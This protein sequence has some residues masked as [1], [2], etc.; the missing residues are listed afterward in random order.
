MMI[1]VN[2]L[3]LDFNEDIE[4][5]KQAKVFE[6]IDETVGDFSYSFSLGKTSRN[7]TVL[8]IET[9]DIAN[10]TIYRNV[11]AEILDDDGVTIYR[12]ILRVE[13]INEVIECSFY[14]GN[15]NWISKITGNLSDLDFSEYDINLTEANIIAS[16]ASTEGIVF[17][18][19]DTGGLITRSQP[20]LKIEDFNG[21]MYVKTIFKKIFQGA[22]IKL[23]G[24]LINDFIY[25]NSIVV[26]NNKDQSDIDNRSSYVLKNTTTVLTSSGTSIKMTWNDDSTSPYFDGSEDNFNLSLSRYEADVKMVVQVVC[27]LEFED[28]ATPTANFVIVRVNGSPT[29]PPTSIGSVQNIVTLRKLV[30]LNAGDY[31][32][33]FAQY[34]SGIVPNLDVISGTLKIT[35]VF[36]Y[37]VNGSSAVPNWTRQD[38]VAQYLNLFNVVTDYDPVSKELTCNFFDRI[39]AR[40]SIDISNYIQPDPP[41]D[42]ED[43]ISNYGRQ[44]LFSYDDGDDEELRSYNVTKFIKYGSGIIEVENDFI[45]ET[46]DIIESDFKPPISYINGALDASIERINIIELEEDSETEVT[47]VTDSSGTAR[48]HIAEDFYIVGDLVRVSDSSNN[49]YNGDFL[50]QTIGSGYIEL[51]GLAYDSNATAKVSKLNYKYTDNDDVFLLINIPN[52]AVSNFS[53]LSQIYLSTSNYSSFAYGYFNLLN[54]GRAVN[55]SYKQSLSFGSVDN[56]LNY[57]RTLLD[58][59]WSNFDNILND[60][61]KLIPIAHLPRNVF[62]SLSPLNPVFIKTEQSSNL[63]YLNKIVGYKNSYSPCQI[64]LI[65]L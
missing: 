58:T 24:E 29:S 54:Q 4:I 20:T 1:K 47:S 25:N 5:E 35:P 13:R 49:N 39:K 37:R 50:V 19:I 31:L 14:S 52:Y 15:Y 46:A 18:L 40:P 62:K 3:F 23:K 22:G 44:N 42:F 26:K 12:G 7:L 41:V 34:I 48:L 32:E 45:E 53:S 17:P 64:E 30:T 55:D 65:K 8:G 2:G 43:F 6:E 11:N 28:A 16:I 57:Q 56:P 33:I 9:V 60:P 10:K 63:Y 21:C 27:T 51:N 59:Y 38:F 36:I 61:V